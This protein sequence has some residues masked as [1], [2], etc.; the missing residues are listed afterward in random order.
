MEV[1]IIIVSWNVREYLRKCLEAVFTMI[2]SNTS[3]EVIVV[4]N[5]SVDGSLEMVQNDYPRVKLISNMYNAGFA[6]ACNQG[7]QIASGKHLLFLNDDT[8]VKAGAVERLLEYLKNNHRVG[9]A[10]ARLLNPDGTLQLGTARRF[11]S[12]LTAFLL[13]SGCF[14]WFGWLKAV[15]SYLYRGENF[16]K[17]REVDQVMGA[18]LMVSKD[19]WNRVGGFDERFF[20]LFEEVDLCRRVALAGYRVAVVARAE[21]VHQKGPSFKQVPKLRNYRYL[22]RSLLLYG[23][24]HFNFTANLLLYLGNG[25]GWVVAAAVALLR[26][27]KRVQPA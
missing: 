5:H 23:D 16:Y 19:I 26:L 13:I 9:I 7:A 22:S 10:G 21:I 25:I 12:P 18:S 6:A 24:K 4:D 27:H 11:P 8:E 14:R 3:Y 20:I 15:K 17:D 1:S 2:E